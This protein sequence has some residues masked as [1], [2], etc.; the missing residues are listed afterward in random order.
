M[1]EIAFLVFFSIFNHRR[2]LDS[3]R[4]PVVNF[5]NYVLECRRS[6]GAYR[7]RD[8]FL[9]VKIDQQKAVTAG[10]DQQNAFGTVVSFLPCDRLCETFAGMPSCLPSHLWHVAWNG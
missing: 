6:S 8:N 3:Q 7:L 4:E 10:K 5:D 9:N 1:I 2:G